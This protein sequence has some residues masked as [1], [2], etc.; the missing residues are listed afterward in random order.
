MAKTK[1]DPWVCTECGWTS[2]RWV[3]RCGECQTWGSVAERGAPT[4]A[5]VASN[6]PASRAVPIEIKLPPDFL[7]LAST[8][9]ADIEKRLAGTRV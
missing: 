8:N 4:L 6:V 7:A 5:T 9:A 2:V 3:G 1:Q